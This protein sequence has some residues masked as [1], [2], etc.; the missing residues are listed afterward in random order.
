MWSQF[1]NPLGSMA[2]SALAAAIPLAVLLILMGGLR[3]SG[4]VSAA[5][6]LGASFLLAVLIWKM[7]VKLA[8]L[9]AGFGVIFALWPILWIVFTAL[10][11]YNLSVE[12]GK[13]DLFRRWMVEH[14]SDDARLQAI[15]VAF[16]FGALLEGMAGFGA[17]VAIA[18]FLLLGLGFTPKKAVVIALIANTAPV[19]FG[20]LGIPIV[21]LAG[22]TGLDQMKLSAMVGRQLPFLSFVLPTYIAWVA[23]DRKS[24]RGALGGALVCGGAFALTQFA[25]SNFWG[26]YAADIAAALASIAAFVAYLK[27]RPKAA[28]NPV[29]S[30]PQLTFGESLAAWAPWVALAAVMIPWSGLNVMRFGQSTLNIPGLH[31]AVVLTLYQR[32]YPAGYNF[33]P[34]SAG[35]G[36]LVAVLLTALIFRAQPGIVLRSAIG[37]LRQ[38]LKPG[39]TVCLIVAL[40]YLYN[41]SGMIYTLGAA[42]ASLGPLFPFFSG[43]LGWVA[44]FLSG[45]DTASNLLFGNLQVAAANQIG[46]NPILL[47]AT[48]SSGA[49]A[50]KMISPQN[51]AVGVT[52]VGLIGKEGD[53]VRATF[54]HSILMATLLSALSLAQ[55][56]WLKWMIP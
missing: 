53:I 16:C 6:G 26:P 22:V 18:A 4:A 9:S 29:S 35:T 11:L 43:F 45:S 44:C 12:T 3:K 21:A 15:L 17:P 51:V 49:V 23:G 28:G 30:G 40:A 20:S 14:A 48:N 1:L 32:P 36:A 5:W 25:V 56:Y 55:A 8:A 54:W 37:T 13:F 34:L 27:L 42:L 33:Q 38:L 10:W 24:L 39:L 47:A 41:Y 7:P 46:V 50:G 52:T 31:N 19:A 2:L